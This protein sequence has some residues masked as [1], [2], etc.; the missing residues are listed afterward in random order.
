MFSLSIT[1]NQFSDL[2]NLHNRVFYPL[3]HFV[4]EKKFNEIIYK[5]QTNKK[6]FPIPIFFGISEKKF[7]VLKNLKFVKLIYK[8]KYL[9]LI[10][11][12]SIFK[13]NPIIFGKKILG[14]NF[15]KHPYFRKYIDEN[16]AFIDFEFKKLI[17]KNLKDKNFVSP[18]KFKKIIKKKIK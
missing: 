4:N 1:K 3:T 17:K 11:I 14:K 13:F 10:K 9:A 16:F 7:Y 15:K 18:K 12:K 5:R 6:F 8:K 2:L